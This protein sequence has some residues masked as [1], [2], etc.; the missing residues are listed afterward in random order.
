MG[1]DLLMD[2]PHVTMYVTPRLLE[3]NSLPSRP[4]TYLRTLEITAELSHL[5][6]ALYGSAL[7]KSE[8][9]C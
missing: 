9:R 8:T 7:Q 2:V 4:T 1:T 6:I 3:C 5:L